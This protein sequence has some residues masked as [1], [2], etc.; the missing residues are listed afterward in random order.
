MNELN[1]SDDGL[2][3]QELL[4][5]AEDAGATVVKFLY[6]SNSYGQDSSRLSTPRMAKYQVRRQSRDV[7]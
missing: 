2:M 7:Y 1:A 5:N 3:T 6:D 4:Q